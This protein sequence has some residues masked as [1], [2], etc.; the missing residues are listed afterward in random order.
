MTRCLLIVGLLLTS[1]LGTGCIIIDV[2]E[3]YSC[4][5]T[6]VGPQETAEQ[7]IDEASRA[8]CE[9]SQPQT[10]AAMDKTI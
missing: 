8:G 9:S 7:Q 1:F 3:G 5:Q 6:V 10:S 4:K 2:D